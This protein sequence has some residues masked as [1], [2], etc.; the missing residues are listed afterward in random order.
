MSSEIFL[1]LSIDTPF[2]YKWVTCKRLAV[3]VGA[4][5]IHSRRLAVFVGGVVVNTFACVATGRVNGV[6][7]TV[8][9]C[10]TAFL[11]GNR[12]ENVE[13]VTH[14]FFFAVANY[15]IVECKRSANKP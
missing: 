8:V 2:G 1:I 10:A 3:K 14:T 11:L 12:A 4:V 7:V 9:Y 15:A 6:L 13:K 5:H